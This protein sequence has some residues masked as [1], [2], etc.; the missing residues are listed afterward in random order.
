[1]DHDTKGIAF[2]DDPTGTMN[3]RRSDVSKF[4]DSFETLWC[5]ICVGYG[6]HDTAHHDTQ[7]GF[8]SGDMAFIKEGV[9]L[10]LTHLV[11]KRGRIESVRGTTAAIAIPGK[12][13]T[14]TVSVPVQFL[15]PDV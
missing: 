7:G 11:G 9:E 5:G 8:K 10:D 3:A 4:D 1:M 12:S 13:G 15:T 6:F 2:V 14:M